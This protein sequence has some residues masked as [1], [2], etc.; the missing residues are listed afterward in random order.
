VSWLPQVVVIGD[1]NLDL[2]LRGDIRPRFGQAEQLLDAAEL[3]LGGSASLVAHGL[4]RLDVPVALVAAVGDDAFGRI[5]VD[6]LRAS[7][8][9][10][11]FVAR[12]DD[13]PTGLSVVLS[14]EDRAILTHPGAIASLRLDDLPDSWAGV[15]HVHV[16]SPYL[17]SLL[18]PAL[19]GVLG[20]LRRAGVTV[21]I[22]TNDDPLREW[23]HLTDLLGNADVVLPNRAE[24]VRWASALNLD[25]GDWRTAAE[26]VARLGPA[27]V[28][29][30]G[31]AGGSC[32][33]LGRAAV[34]AKAP[35]VTAVD[36]TGAGDSFDAGWIAAALA[37][38]DD[39]TA[40]T[41]AVT[42][43]ALSTRTTG[44]ADAQPSRTELAAVVATL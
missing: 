26:A 14:D 44:G 41:W 30:S 8:V 10:V 38:Q 32:H 20:R 27:V 22:D 33:R 40:L 19:G 34:V 5:A 37:G 6:L 35:E 11:S 29:K 24:V 13:I 21:S 25:S 31:R 28:V 7:G 16:A 36:T 39:G 12:R 42:A 1:A 23:Q 4:A 15:R 3:T 2:V 43:G 17:A 9:D 18:R